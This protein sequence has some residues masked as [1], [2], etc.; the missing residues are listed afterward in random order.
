MQLFT[1][2]VFTLTK[3]KIN[4][5]NRPN[6][7]SSFKKNFYQYQTEQTLSHSHQACTQNSFRYENVIS[8]SLS[9]FFLS[10]SLSN[11]YTLLKIS[12]ISDSLD[13]HHYIWTQWTITTPIPHPQTLYTLS[14]S[15]HS[16]PLTCSQ[17]ST[18]CPTPSPAHYPSSPP[19][20]FYPTSDPAL[21]RARIARADSGVS[22]M[23][24]LS[25][26]LFLQ[27]L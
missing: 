24:K 5:S 12:P 9:H 21:S 1:E 17:N 13:P 25:S 23:R 20:T 22:T 2:R 15:L 7:V 18:P 3:K 19:L 16:T 10:L 11:I 26:T 6:L 4:T 14:N 8:F 27:Y